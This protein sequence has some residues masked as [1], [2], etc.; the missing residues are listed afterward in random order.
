MPFGS[1]KNLEEVLGTFQITLHQ[2]RFIQPV[3]FPVDERFRQRLEFLRQ[4]APVSASEE[5]ICEFMIAPILQEV[6]VRYSDALMMWSHVSMSLDDKVAGF[7]D[8]FF[9]RR[10]PLGPVRD[11][12]YVIFSQAKRDDFDAAWGQCLAAMLAALKFRVQPDGKML[13]GVTNGQIWY[14]GKLHGR[15]LF[16][17]PRE[18]MI[19]KLPDLFAALSDVMR[20]AREQVLLTPAA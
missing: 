1:Y 7:P 11:K 18:F 9:A 10:S 2:E 19:D 6:W 16:H 17:D 4:N 8:Y 15:D 20:Q 3:P 14:F 12:P 5:A 13:G